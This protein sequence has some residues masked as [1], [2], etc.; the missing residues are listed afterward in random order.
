MG[1]NALE[2][3]KDLLAVMADAMELIVGPA[4]HTWNTALSIV[5]HKRGLTL[6]STDFYAR[7]LDAEYEAGQPAQVSITVTRTGI[8]YSADEGEVEFT[9]KDYNKGFDC[10]V[11]GKFF[12]R[13]ERV[14]SRIQLPGEKHLHQK[15]LCVGCVPDMLTRK[16][17][18]KKKKEVS[19]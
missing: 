1:Q 19:E 11:C 15:E 7:L 8:E 5:L 17:S 3:A 13:T 18:W 16:P 9:F 6:L 14:T 12:H 4:G 10:A 2:D